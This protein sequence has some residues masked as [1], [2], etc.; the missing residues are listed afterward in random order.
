MCREDCCISVLVTGSLWLVLFVYI[1]ID[2]YFVKLVLLPWPSSPPLQLLL[3]LQSWLTRKVEGSVLQLHAVL[4]MHL[5][6]ITESSCGIPWF[7]QLS[8]SAIAYHWVMCCFVWGCLEMHTI[9][10]LW[11][12]TCVSFQFKKINRWTR[13]QNQRLKIWSW[14]AIISRFCLALLESKVSSGCSAVCAVCLWRGKGKI[15]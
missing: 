8:L 15:N 4:L 10:L 2:G 13:S 12:F 5:C 6:N 1:Y 7:L 11:A 9:F 3:R 14:P